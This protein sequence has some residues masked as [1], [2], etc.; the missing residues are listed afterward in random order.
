MNNQYDSKHIND[1]EPSIE[2]EED[3]E[4]NSFI[5][6]NEV[7]EDQEALRE[8]KK[9]TNYRKKRFRERDNMPIFESGI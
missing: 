2:E 9:L 7:E 8:L 6:D 3:D 1:S 5:D 4:L